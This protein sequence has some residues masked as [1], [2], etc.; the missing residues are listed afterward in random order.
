MNNRDIDKYKWIV[1]GGKAWAMGTE[2]EYA[3]FVEDGTYEGV[4]LEVIHQYK[5]DTE[6]F[7]DNVTGEPTLEFRQQYNVRQLIRVATPEKFA[8]PDEHSF[9][10]RV[11]PWMISCFGLD[12][13]NNEPKRTYRFLEEALELVQACGCTREDI[14]NL[15]DVI[16]DK[17]AGKAPQ[18][19][20]G[21]MVTLA[22]LC[23]AKKLD[24]EQCA[25]RELAFNWT[26]IEQLRSKEDKRLQPT[27]KL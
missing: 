15:I 13:L 24:M 1:R 11:L 8:D 7:W 14:Y 16:Y 22:A 26:R 18:E 27:E 3:S 21:V 23:L 5:S 12:I 10:G 9:Q 25:E 2:L 19:V 17:P 20:G 6:A 4:D